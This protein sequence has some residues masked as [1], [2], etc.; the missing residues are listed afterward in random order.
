MA[1]VE[2]VEQEGKVGGFGINIPDANC[3]YT[4]GDGVVWMLVESIPDSEWMILSLEPEEAKTQPPLYVWDFDDFETAQMVFLINMYY[5][6]GLLT[7]D[8]ASALIERDEESNQFKK[9]EKM[10][11]VLKNST[12]L[13]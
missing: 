3:F 6:D 8:E 5:Y 1:E 2:Q 4:T 9:T 13:A 10:R 11:S 7:E 12:R